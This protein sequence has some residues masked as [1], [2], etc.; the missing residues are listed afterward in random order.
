LKEKYQPLSI[1]VYGSFADGSDNENSDLDILLISKDSTCIHDTSI[2]NGIQLDAFVKPKDS[3]ADFNLE[4][5]V[6]IFDGIVVFDTDDFGKKL[7][8]KVNRYLDCLPKKTNEE[9]KEEVSWCQKMLL[10]IQRNDTEGLYRWHWLLI[11]SLSIY[12]DVI[13]VSYHGPKK[14]LIFMKENHPDAYILYDSALRKMD[15][16][17]IRNWIFFISEAL[18][19]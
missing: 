15:S 8:N 9:K 19:K 16:V 10:R 6:Q 1:I 12:F 4:D 18:N 3:F 13:D 11:D 14:A 7:I 5:Y 17:S 2:Q